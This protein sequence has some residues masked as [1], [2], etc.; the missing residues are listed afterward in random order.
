MSQ[1]EH[2]YSWY[3][4]LDDIATI[5]ARAQRLPKPVTGLNALPAE[6]AITRLESALAQVF[7]VTDKV[8]KALQK[9]VWHCHSGAIARY[10]DRLTVV[11]N[12]T[13]QP[14]FEP[15]VKPICLTGRA[16]DGKSEIAQAAQRLLQGADSVLVHADY[17]RFRRTGLMYEKIWGRSSANEVFRMMC[18]R[19]GYMPPSGRGDPVT[20]F[21]RGAYRD[22]L[23]ALLLD[24]MQ[25]LSLSNNASAE[26]TNT[27]LKARKTGVP[28]IYV[29]NFSLLNKLLKGRPE[30][31]DRLLPN[32]YPIVPDDPA[33][34]DWYLIVQA[35]LGVMEE[36]H[37]IE[38]NPQV[39][40][41][42]GDETATTP[43][44]LVQLLALGYL[45]AR[46][47]GAQRMTLEHLGIAM[48]GYEFLTSRELVL[49][50]KKP[51]REKARI[52]KY[53]DT[54]FP[55]GLLRY[56]ELDDTK[57]TTTATIQTQALLQQML[58]TERAQANA[59]SGPSNTRARTPRAKSGKLTADALRLADQSVRI[60]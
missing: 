24:E 42:L 54:F 2:W 46:R 25:H 1:S 39:A 44:Y 40:K 20:Q 5:R 50:Q 23:A 56:L 13:S 47:K 19:C 27:L 21:S 29:C 59:M 60:K 34:A 32:I 37:A 30:D 52:S 48:R 33:G 22:G 53:E 51:S 10:P 41:Y 58:P 9:I 14:D 15:V 7:V 18:D 11:R 49:A 8:G 38:L 28:L 35:L 16:G 31:I 43:R 4:G 57:H 12:V 3:A 36:Y 26:I 17:P 55:E 45:T 6:V